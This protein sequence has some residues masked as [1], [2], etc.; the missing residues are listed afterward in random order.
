M[1]KML[2][3]KEYHAKKWKKI[4][5]L[6]DCPFCGY[7]DIIWKWK[8]WFIIK[9]FSPYSWDEKHLMAIP[10]AH[11]KYSVELLEEEFAWLKEVQEFVKNFYWEEN[12]F[13]CT[14]ETMWNRSVEHFHIHFVPWRLQGKYLRKMLENQGFPIKEEI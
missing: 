10:F 4:Y 13:S 5:W 2:T 11:K 7:S 6:D 1:Q 14:R 12:F 9:N 8:Y 3:R